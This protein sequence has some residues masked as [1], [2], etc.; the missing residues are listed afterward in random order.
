VR[1]LDRRQ[2]RTESGSSGGFVG[3]GCFDGY[4]MMNCELGKR[5]ARAVCVLEGLTWFGMEL[6]EWVIWLKP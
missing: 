5:E 1:E 2:G 6:I 3:E 4:V